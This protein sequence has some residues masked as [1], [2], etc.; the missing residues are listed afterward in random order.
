MPDR[1]ERISAP[2]HVLEPGARVHILH[3]APAVGDVVA[4]YARG[5][6]RAARVVKVT[7][8]RVLCAYGTPSNPTQVQRHYRRTSGAWYDRVYRE[9]E[10]GSYQVDHT[11]GTH[12]G[13]TIVNYVTRGPIYTT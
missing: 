3:D 6:L 4:I 9:S 2:I 11:P 7:P 12:Y 5:R 13:H 8:T 1:S 10:S